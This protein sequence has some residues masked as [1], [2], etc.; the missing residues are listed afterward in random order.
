[1]IDLGTLG[2]EFSSAK[3]I[4]NLGQVAGRSTIL[5]P[6]PGTSYHCFLWSNQAMT[7]LTPNSP[8]DCYANSINNRGTVV[9]NFAYSVL[10]NQRFYPFVWRDR[11]ITNLNSLLPPNSGWK[12]ETANDIN[13][14]GQIVGTGRFNRE[15]RGVLLT[16]ITIAQ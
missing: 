5:K 11:T 4:N 15:I 8:H 1:M 12:L 9:G 3:T 2:G 13:N 7:D 10:M 14:N 16:P 6:N